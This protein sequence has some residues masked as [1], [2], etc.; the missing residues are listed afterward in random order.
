MCVVQDPHKIEFCDVEFIRNRSAKLLEFVQEVIITVHLFRDQTLQPDFLW[1]KKL[2]VNQKWFNLT[3]HQLARNT[4]TS[5]ESIIPSVRIRII[6]N[7][8]ASGLSLH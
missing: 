6:D 8:D 5:K 7:C 3:R 1:D 4:E 2:A